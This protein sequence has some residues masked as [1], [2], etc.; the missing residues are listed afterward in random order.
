MFRKL[1]SKAVCILILPIKP[2][3]SFHQTKFPVHL[4]TFFSP[5]FFE[6]LYKVHRLLICLFLS[7]NRFVEI[8]IFRKVILVSKL[9][10]FSFFCWMLYWRDC[11][12]YSLIALL[13]RPSYFN[14]VRTFSY[15]LQYVSFQFFNSYKKLAS[16]SRMFA[17]ALEKHISVSAFSLLGIRSIEV[18]WV[19]RNK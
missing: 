7:F 2:L 14:K 9:I 17:N 15:W 11:G 19:L 6:V 10:K 1:N 18:A 5:F 8:L 4:H 16:L 12:T 13:D 3:L